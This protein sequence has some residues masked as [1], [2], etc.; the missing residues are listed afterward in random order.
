MPERQHPDLLS[1]VIR[2][3]RRGTA[4]VVAVVVGLQLAIAL[5]FLVID[6]STVRG[7]PGPLLVLIGIAAS[8]VLGARIGAVLTAFSVFLGV[9][10]L[11][12]NQVASPLVWIPAA[13]AVGLLGDNVRRGEELRRALVTEL[14][15]GLVALSH[16][17]RVGPLQVISRYLPAEREQI[18]AGDFYGV[19]VQPDGDVA[20]MVGDVSGHGPD[21]AAVATHLRAAW[22][23][24]AVAGV[25]PSQI[26]RVLNDSL[27]AESMAGSSVRFATV[28][29]ALV[30]ADRA[31]STMVLAGHPPPVLVTADETHS[32]ELR[33]DPV[34]G[35]GEFTWHAQTVELPPGEWSMLIYTDGLIEGR[36][37]PDGPRPFGLERLSGLLAEIHPPLAERDVDE[38]LGAVRTANG[39][40]MPDDIVVLAVSPADAAAADTPAG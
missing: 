19:V 40:P 38:L 31:Q 26:M 35:I 6:P 29:L 30:S 25:P 11:G 12:E 1:R 36:Q 7:V 13:I 2:A 21:A 28:C 22:R 10:I 39:G 9:T 4:V 23:G 33:P 20:L 24:L 14:R 5:P 37:Q 32:F 16:D 8:F 17:P 18:L 15:A 3:N 34:L 27:M